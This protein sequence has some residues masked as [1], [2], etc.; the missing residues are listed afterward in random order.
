[1]YLFVGANTFLYI[2][3][4]NE[5]INTQSQHFSAIQNSADQQAIDNDIKRNVKHRWGD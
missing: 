3:V 1:M 4:N 5:Q 2:R